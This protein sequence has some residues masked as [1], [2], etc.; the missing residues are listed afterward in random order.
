[1]GRGEGR[2]GGREGGTGRGRGWKGG[3]WKGGRDGETERRGVGKGERG[4]D[5]GEK[6]TL[7]MGTP[8]ETKRWEGRR[9]GK[10]IHPACPKDSEEDEVRGK[11]VAREEGR[12][13]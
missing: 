6:W 1:M 2:V 12:D 4:R 9:V 7:C 5:S 11:E 10:Q 13:D 8:N 3:G